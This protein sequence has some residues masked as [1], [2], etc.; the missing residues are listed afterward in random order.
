MEYY[1]DGDNKIP[2]E[3]V[4]KSIKERISNIN[5]LFVQAMAEDVD[6]CYVSGHDSKY[7]SM[8]F[9]PGEEEEILEEFHSE[10]FKSI[11]M[12]IPS[13]SKSETSTLGS[14]VTAIE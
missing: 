7:C 14:A 13:F 5:S 3:I 11:N 1:D 4:R 12:L 6:F 9:I 2:E 8:V 10:L